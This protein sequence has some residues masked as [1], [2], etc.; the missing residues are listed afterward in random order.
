MRA[1]APCF[2]RRIALAW[3]T[4]LLLAAMPWST[5]S[6]QAAAEPS[7][8]DD[9]QIPLGRRLRIHS[10]LLGEDREILVHLPAGYDQSRQR[11]P[12]LYL[13]DG[14]A[15]FE[16]ASGIVDFLARNDRVPAL[17]LVAIPNMERRWRDL[18]MPLVKDEAAIREI[19]SSGL[20]VGGA[21][22]FLDFIAD[23]LMP[24]VDAR[25]RTQPYRILSG[26]SLGGL[27]DVYAMLE[28]PDVFQAHIAVSPTLSW[29]RRAWVDIAKQR[30]P[31]LPGRR[32]LY[33]SWSDDEVDIRDAGQSLVDWLRVHRSPDPHSHNQT[34]TNLIWKSRYYPGDDHGTTPLRTLYD[35]LEWLY[36]DWKPDFLDLRGQ[37]PASL[38]AEIR[39]HYAT[40]SQK[41]GYAV[42][43]S[44]DTRYALTERLL[45]QQLD[46]EALALALQN[47]ADH[48]GNPYVHRQIAEMLDKLGRSTEALVAYRRYLDLPDEYRDASESARRRQQ[49]EARVGQA[50]R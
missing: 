14:N 42:E 41:Y 48:P 31:S 27:F 45:E 12:V 1:H 19:A 40:L 23:E 46:S 21:R 39:A 7:C 24:W 18:T 38:G 9:E 10:K 34:L 4:I 8:D 25:Y 20:E 13:L 49:L 43:P 37:D 44:F 6:A 26:H 3:L 36:A 17:I 33:L 50:G 2:T 22:T 29:D 35:G 28:R 15:H 16:Y 11:Y 5:T 30:I 32:A 47:A